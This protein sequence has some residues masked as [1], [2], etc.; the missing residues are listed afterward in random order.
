MSLDR[1]KWP[2]S[3]LWHGWLPGLCGIRESDPWAAS[4][5]DLASVQISFLPSWMLGDIVYLLSWLRG[6]V[7]RESILRIFKDLYNYFISSHLRERDTILLRAI[8]CGE[9]WN[10]FL[11]GRA[12]KEDVPCLFC[13]KKDGDGHLFWECSFPPFLHVRELPEFASLMSLDRSK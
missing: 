10:G 4:F 13:G 2:R 1:S 6:K 8:L 11:L 7:S 12:K 9:V 5:H 3:L